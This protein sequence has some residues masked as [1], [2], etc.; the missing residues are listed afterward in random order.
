MPET[1]ATYKLRGFVSDLGG[2]V[3]ESVPGL[4]H[5]RLGGKGCIYTASR[6]PLSWL[7]LGR[8][9]SPIDLE[10]HLHRPDAAR[11]NLQITIVLRPFGKGISND[12]SWRARC[13]QIFCDL[14]AYL[15]AQ[16]ATV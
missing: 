7:G 6:S 14:R 16:G 1:I 5:I 2:E 10:M 15:M 4:I 3:V 8:H 11:D 9:H 12:E 13:A